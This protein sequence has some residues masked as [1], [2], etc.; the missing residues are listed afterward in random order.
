MS[1]EA[2]RTVVLAISIVAA[3]YDTQICLLVIFYLGIQF[4]ASIFDRQT[5]SER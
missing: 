2:K 5:G 4:G 3:A 1:Q